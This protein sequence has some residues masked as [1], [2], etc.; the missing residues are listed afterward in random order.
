MVYKVE[1]NKWRVFVESFVL[2]ILILIIGFSLGFFFESYRLSEISESYKDY[3][4]EALD[5]KL[6]NYYYQI[7]DR[8]SCEE[9]INQNF[10]FAD[11]IYNKGLELEKYE[12]VSQLTDDL[13]REKKRYVLLKTELWLNSILLKEKCNDP[14]DTVV[15]FY[16]GNPSNNLK[17]SEQK[18]LSNV[19]KTVK[20]NK[21]NEIILIPI[22]GDLDIGVLDLQKRLYNVSYFPAVLI[23][24]DILLEGF[25]SVEEI[26]SYLD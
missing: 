13:A 20:E 26:E 11:D 5:L 17:V 14:F 8:S 6:Q 18:V 15:Y 16:S 4:V 3:E 22:A 23:N 9:A 24:E 12:E 25:K 21:G 1:Y 2:T 10:I 19:L 7:M